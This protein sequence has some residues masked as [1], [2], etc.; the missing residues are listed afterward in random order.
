MAD[1]FEF[2]EGKVGD[3]IDTTMMIYSVVR[4]IR[5]SC[6]EYDY[7][8]DESRLLLFTEESS[9]ANHT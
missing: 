7:E 6:Y 8:H 5:L 2:K 9:I 3:M 4:T 1:E